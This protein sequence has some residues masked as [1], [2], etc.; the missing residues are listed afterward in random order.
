[1]VANIS[2]SVSAELG[3]GGDGLGAVHG[4]AA[5]GEFSLCPPPP[6]MSV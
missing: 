6:A 3:D 5:A 1:M 4:H 2:V